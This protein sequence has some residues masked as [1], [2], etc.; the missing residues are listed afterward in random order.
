VLL[1]SALKLLGVDTALTAVL[2]LAVAVLA[3]PVWMLLRKRHGFPAL[4]RHE[5]AVP[6]A[7]LDRVA[8]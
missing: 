1:A 3:G 4:P 2:L 5:A 6:A 8:A 7:Q